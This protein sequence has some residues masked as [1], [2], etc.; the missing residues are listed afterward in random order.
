MQSAAQ[1]VGY[2]SI[3]AAQDFCLHSILKALTSFSGRRTAQEHIYMI[4]IQT[5][6]KSIFPT[7]LYVV[8]K[9]KHV[10]SLLTHADPM[11]TL[12]VQAVT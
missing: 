6:G 11:A 12:P 5:Y 8:I 4:N 2:F 7:V 1:L 3:E 9:L 10:I